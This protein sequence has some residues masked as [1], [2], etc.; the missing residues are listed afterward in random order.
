VFSYNQNVSHRLQR[1]LW[2]DLHCLCALLLTLVIFDS[3]AILSRL[4]TCITAVL[5]EESHISPF[6][7][8][9]GALSYISV[10][11]VCFTA[12]SRRLRHVAFSIILVVVIIS[13][14]KECDQVAVY[15]PFER[16][17]ITEWEKME[18]DFCILTE[19][20][21]VCLVDFRRNVCCIVID[22]VDIQ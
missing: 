18:I 22:A 5:L 4:Y 20:C 17:G 7:C 6:H 10:L 8:A 3:A 19:T 12:G 16:N 13:V 21:G 2:W 9:T 11:S 14:A 1:A 15:E